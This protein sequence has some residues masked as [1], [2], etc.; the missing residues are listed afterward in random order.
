M[1]AINNIAFWDM[2]RCGLIMIYWCLEEN[3]KNS[4]RPYVITSQTTKKN[5]V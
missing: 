2:M 3:E 1:V 5:S 4:A